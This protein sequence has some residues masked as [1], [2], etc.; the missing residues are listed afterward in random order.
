MTTTNVTTQQARDGLIN[1][2]NAKWAGA[3][4][5][6]SIPGAGA[7]WAA[8]Y[9][10]GEPINAQ[11]GTLN[12]NQ[13]NDFRAAIE[14]WDSYIAT[15]LNEVS[16]ATPGQ[17]RVAFTD[18]TALE[19][20][21]NID[22][23][24]YGPNTGSETPPAGD[25]WIDETL[26]GTSFA[27][28]TSNF[29]LLL[30]ELGH[31]LGLKHSFES[32][33]VP[34]GYD[35]KTY[36][37]M[38]YSTEDYFYTW[39]GGGGSI[40]YSSTDT[41]SY[42][43]M[44]LDILA[45]QSQYGADTATG[46]GNTTYTFTDADF[47]GRRSLYDASGIDTLNFSAI[48]RGSNID[49]RPGAY[50][51]I[52]YYNVEDQ[53]DDLSAQ[54]G[55]G[56][57]N[58]IRTT[59]TNASR[60]AYEWERNLGISFSTTIE[61]AVGTA[62]A[63]TITGNTADNFLWGKN[64]V[65]VLDGSYGNDQLYGGNGGDTL[66]GG[67][68]LDYARYDDANYGNLVI[69]LL[70]PASNTGA[71]AG[72]TYSSIE[73]IVGG[74]GNDTITG[75]NGTNYLIGSGG[76]DTLNGGNATDYL[77]GGAGGDTLNGGAGL[78]YA[79]YDDASWGNLVINLLNPALNTGAAAGDTYISIEGVIGG[80]GIDTITGDN[81]GNFLRGLGGNDIIDGGAGNDHLYGGL[82]ADTLIG[83]SGA[84]DYVNYDDANY[85]NLVINL[86][87]PA[88]NTGAAAGDTFSGI[89]GV[90]GGSGNDTIT[91]DGGNNYL[92]GG[93]GNDTIDGG[94]GNDSLYGGAGADTLIGGAGT[95]DYARYDDSNYGN[96]VVSLA[97]PAVNT[98]A[99]AGDTFSGIEGLFGGIGND[100]LIGNSGINYLNGNS[101][102]DTLT[103]NGG[104]DFFIFTTA[105]SGG[106]DTITDFAT[107]V[108]RMQL[109]RGVFTAFT[110]AHTLTTAEFHAGAGLTA[111]SETDDRIV[112]NTTTGALYYDA[113]G[114][115]GAASV[116]FATLQGHPTLAA[117][118]ILIV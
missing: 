18:A 90:V 111:A 71:A 115:G 19:G 25:V 29:T 54:Y 118:D 79:R 110:T 32:P 88:A 89:E 12:T 107:S 103:G 78:D 45:I 65:D 16:D 64:G 63:D 21:P 2:L 106:I 4:I 76:N 5:T 97:N 112:Y 42:T 53:I 99:A 83:G 51:D 7:V 37:V 14:I 58:F 102:A 15:N 20:N 34:A 114:S 52:G 55:A 33:T 17:I 91:G 105:I 36:T 3:T 86:A 46:A 75:D 35:Y 8:G 59:L 9:G 104:S 70:T 72:D 108:D 22:A 95:I 113:D 57:E 47:N 10:Q 50:S 31:S 74:V 85:G 92:L 116:H 94:A 30:H 93:L 24:A 40:S 6:Y 81:A 41:V 68:G 100:T 96:L 67:G 77:Y 28:G 1:T 61:R 98:G 23:Y 60:P 48:T 117:A 43:P 62:F 82:G 49:L 26:K 101:G 56:F 80:A 27:S 11:Y 38:S 44:V 13:A 87:N 69:N 73:G 109:S 84:L 39:S 66:I